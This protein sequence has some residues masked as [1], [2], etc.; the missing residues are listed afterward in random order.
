[1]PLKNFRIGQAENEL[2]IFTLFS[3]CKRFRNSL[4]GATAALLLAMAFL[5]HVIANL[6]GSFRRAVVAR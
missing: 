3:A 2:K 6:F 5:G 4:Y 1:M